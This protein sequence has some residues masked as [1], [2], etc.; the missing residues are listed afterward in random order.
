[1]SEQTDTAAAIARLTEQIKADRYEREQ[2]RHNLDQKLT[3]IETQTEKT[4]GRVTRQELWR[5]FLLGGVAAL[6]APWA[7]KAAQLLSH[8]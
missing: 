8:P 1:M 3:R 5:M 4:N 6:S 2:Y 7:I